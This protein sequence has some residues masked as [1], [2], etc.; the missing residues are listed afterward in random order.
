MKVYFSQLITYRCAI[1]EVRYGYNDE[2]TDKVFPLQP[3]DPADPHSVPYEAKIYMN[4]PPKTA[5]MSVQLTYVDG[6]TSATRS[7]NAPK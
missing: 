7:F 2:P 1:H 6:T 5:A 4:V 3:C